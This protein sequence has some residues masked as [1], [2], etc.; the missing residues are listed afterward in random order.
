MNYQKVKWHSS[1]PGERFW[2]RQK[3]KCRTLPRGFQCL[4]THFVPAINLHV[5]FGKQ[6]FSSPSATFNILRLLQFFLLSLTPTVI[7]YIQISKEYWHL[8]EC[9]SF[10]RSPV[11]CGKSHAGGLLAQR[12]QIQEGCCQKGDVL[13]PAFV[14]WRG[15]QWSE[16]AG[17]AVHP[18]PTHQLKAICEGQV[19]W[20]QDTEKQ[21]SHWLLSA[22]DW[23][24]SQDFKEWNPCWQVFCGLWV[25][26]NLHAFSF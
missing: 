11:E 15:Y 25:R 23:D 4:R 21:H 2:V 10:Y 20:L 26:Q 16:G 8:A 18:V 24:Q 12:Q 17:H 9:N 19:S 13:P 5:A 3:M 14:P 1:S 7:F 6:N 22:R